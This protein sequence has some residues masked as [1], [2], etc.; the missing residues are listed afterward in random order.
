MDKEDKGIPAFSSLVRAYTKPP[1]DFCFIQVWELPDD[2]ISPL[3]FKNLEYLN[4]EV[5]SINKLHKQVV[6]TSQAC[7]EFEDLQPVPLPTKGPFLNNNYLFYEFM[8]AFREATLAGIN[9]LFHSSFSVLRS[10][11]ELFMF[12]YWWRK[13]CDNS[14]EFDEYYSWLRGERKT[15]TLSSVI[16][17]NYKNTFMPKS[18]KKENDLRGVYEMLCSYVHKP[19]IEEAITTLRGSDSLQLS[20]NVLKY[21]SE[22]MLEVSM[23]M[24]DYAIHFNPQSL[25]PEKLYK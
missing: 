13:K 6:W 2:E 22:I 12:H 3:G 21:W 17:D 10:S 18:A 11:L 4:S 25:F 9:G 23:C 20:S 5:S 14:D 1:A 16:K 7:L 24:L 8:S 19:L 15:S